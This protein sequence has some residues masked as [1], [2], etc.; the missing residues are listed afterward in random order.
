MYLIEY[1]G[2]RCRAVETLEQAIVFFATNKQ[3]TWSLTGLGTNELSTLP[4]VVNGG[5]GDGTGDMGLFRTVLNTG[6]I[7]PR[8]VHIG[9]GL[10]WTCIWTQTCDVGYNVHSAQI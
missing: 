1:K 3:L 7:L 10:R 9:L 5:E 4:T 2:C 6:Q 8:F